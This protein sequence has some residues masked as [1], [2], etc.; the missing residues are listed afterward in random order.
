LAADGT[1]TFDEC[2]PHWLPGASTASKY[3]RLVE[4]LRAG[5]NERGYV[6]G[7]NTIIEFRWADGNSDRLPQL[8]AELV[9][10]GIDVLITH[11]TPGTPAAKTATRTIPIVM[12]VSGD[13][14]AAGLI[15]SIAQPG[16][17]VT[18]S[19]FFAPELAAKRLEL[20][21]Q[22]LPR[23]KRAAVVMNSTNAVSELV[24]HQMADTAGRLNIELGQF[25]ATSVSEL[26]SSISDISANKFDALVV[27]EDGLTIANAP[28][29]AELA[30]QQ[31]LPLAGFA[32]L[33]RLGALIGYGADLPFLF[34]RAAYFVDMILQGNKPANLPVERPTK[35][36]FVINLGSAKA[37][38][39]VVPPE[40]Q[41]SADTVIE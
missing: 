6:E 14:V 39:I 7:R 5:L 1:G 8:A 30:A 25:P 19:T 24:L 21:K 16:G 26:R 29:I 41:G 12:A 37:L 28:L 17:N 36:L 3:A 9:S 20:L 40:L 4:A 38:G 31:R 33:A 11:G 27:F 2:P 32:D 18:G 10:L 35:F 22:F 34:R 15:N 13:A 23:L